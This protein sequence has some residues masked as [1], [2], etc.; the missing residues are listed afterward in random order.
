MEFGHVPVLFDEVMEALAVKPGGTYVDGTVGGGGH[1]SG[2]CERLSGS[3]HLVAVDRD[4]EA[5]AAADLLYEGPGEVIVENS[6]P[7]ERM[8]SLSRRL[9]GLE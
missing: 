6:M 4:A 5:L 1:S 9:A 7:G 2:I 3:G 8:V